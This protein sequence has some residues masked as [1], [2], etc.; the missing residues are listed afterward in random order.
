MK[1]IML[2]MMICLLLV[3]CGSSYPR[4]ERKGEIIQITLDEAIAKME[5]EEEFVVAFETDLC[6]YC[7]QFHSEFDEYIENHHVV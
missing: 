5:Q 6:S 1:K 7:Q 3:G 4:D 2:W